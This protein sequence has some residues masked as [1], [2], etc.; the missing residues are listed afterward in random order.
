[1]ARNYDNLRYHATRQPGVAELQN[2]SEMFTNDARYVLFVLFLTLLACF[3]STIE[4]AGFFRSK[5][6]SALRTNKVIEHAV[7]DVSCTL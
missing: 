7:I 6:T 2:V 5:G 4:Y 3:R 1:M